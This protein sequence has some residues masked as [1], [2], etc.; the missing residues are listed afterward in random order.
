MKNSSFDYR[1]LHPE[2][3]NTIVRA[4]GNPAQNSVHLNHKIYRIRQ[5]L[6]QSNFMQ[7]VTEDFSSVTSLE[8][9]LMQNIIVTDEFFR[10]YEVH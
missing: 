5:K 2:N 9:K 8:R 3:Q 6:Q 1:P 10:T 7:T 4:V